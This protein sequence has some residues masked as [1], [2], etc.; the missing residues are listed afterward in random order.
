MSALDG[1]ALLE[2]GDAIARRY[3]KQVGADVAN[4]LRAEAVLRALRSPPPDGRVEPWLERIYKN[5]LIDHWRRQPYAIASIDDLDTIATAST[6]ED[7]VLAH[8]R[9]LHVRACLHRLPREARRVLLARYWGELDECTTATRMG[10][11]RPTVRTRIHR[12][13]SRL[14]MRL[15]DLRGVL[16]IGGRVTG[17]LATL[18]AAPILV[19]ALMV[20]AATSPDP[21]PTKAPLSVPAAHSTLAVAKPPA[22]VLPP[23]AQ[24]APSLPRG[25][26]RGPVAPATS[27]VPMATAPASTLVTEIVWPERIDIFAEPETSRPPCLVEPPTT[28]ARQI[29]QMVENDL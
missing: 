27:S 3:A 9:R 10:V 18:G 20:A 23:A 16:P 15:G 4:E 2:H 22:Q 29:E 24:V 1:K 26:R 14:R 25:P 11:A 12:A 17:Q 6:P 13:L 28:F 8:E 21:Q 7:A 5:L 19:A